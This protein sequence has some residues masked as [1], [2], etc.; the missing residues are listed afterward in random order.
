M[1]A[2]EALKIADIA[3]DPRNIELAS[4]ICTENGYSLTELISIIIALGFDVVRDGEGLEA[5]GPLLIADMEANRQLRTS[6]T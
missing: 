4:R 5:L 1:S 3:V 6:F 2:S